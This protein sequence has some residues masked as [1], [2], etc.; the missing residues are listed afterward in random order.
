MMLFQGG[1][2]TARQAGAMPKASLD[3]W[4]GAQGLAK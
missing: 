1:K 2:E 3:S 4:L